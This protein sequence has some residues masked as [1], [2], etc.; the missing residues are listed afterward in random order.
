MILHFAGLFGGDGGL[1]GFR[2]LELIGE[3]DGGGRLGFLREI[4]ALE[5]R[6]FLRLA[7]FEN[8][9]VFGFELVDGFT[10]FVADSDV[11][12][13]EV[14]LGGKL[15]DTIRGRWLLAGQRKRKNK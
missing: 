2:Q 1:G 14:A 8:G 13:D 3:G 7:V 12:D 9:E 11:D 6:D 4:L 15:R 10:G 5:D